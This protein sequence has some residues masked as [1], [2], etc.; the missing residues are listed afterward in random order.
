VDQE[1]G[2]RLDQANGPS[3]QAAA[4]SG[5]AGWRHDGRVPQERGQGDAGR[6]H[7]E[8]SDADQQEW[9]LGVLEMKP[10]GRRRQNGKGLELVHQKVEQVPGRRRNAAPARQ[11]AIGAVEH[12]GRLIHQHRHDQAHVARK[13]DQ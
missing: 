12:V 1:L 2:A 11:H 10:D 13:H 5:R 8:A 9:L 4:R 7:H 6:Q 3:Q